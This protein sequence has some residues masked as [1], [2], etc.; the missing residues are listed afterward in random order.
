MLFHE[1]ELFWYKTTINMWS[2]LW[3]LMFGKN[4]V[5]IYMHVF[6]VLIPGRCCSNLKSGIFKKSIPEHAHTWSSVDPD[7]H[8][9]G[10][11]NL[12]ELFQ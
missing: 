5:I 12:N 10:I 4:F 2:V 11:T 6:S 8:W 3:L 1:T 9:N 7:L